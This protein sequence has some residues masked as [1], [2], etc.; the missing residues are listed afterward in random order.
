M[1][2]MIQKSC[3]MLTG[4]LLALTLSP[5][6]FPTADAAE[7]FPSTATIAE[8]MQRAND[9]W[10][11]NNGLGNAGWARGAYYTGNQRAV[12]VLGNRNY[13]R[14]ALAW[15]NANQWRVGPEIN[16]PNV[17]DAFCCG[18]TYIDLYRMD[19]KPL[20]LADIQAKID[21]QVASSAIDGWSWVD[22]FYMQAPT[23]A[24]LGSL[25]GDTN[26]FHKLR[27]MYDDM[28]IRRTLFDPEESLWYRDGDWV[29]PAKVTPSGKKVFWS[30]GDGWVF[31]GLARVIEEMPVGS[32]DR[33]EYVEM[34][35]RMAAAL[36]AV[37]SPDGMWRSSLLD[38]NEYP[39][40]ETSGTAFF[41]FGMAWGIRNGLLPAADYAD[42][43]IKGWN[44]MV[45][46]ALTPDGFLGY[47]QEVGFAPGP[48]DASMTKD[49][50]VGAFLLAGSELYLL[51]PDA[52][53]IRPWAGMDQTNSVKAGEKFSLPLNA[54]LTE[55]YKGSAVSFTWWNGDTQI[56]SGTNTFALL[57]PGQHEITLKVVGSDGNTY[58]DSI[59]VLITET[60]PPPAPEMKM[61]FGFEDSGTVTTDS[62]SGVTLEL[63]D[64]AGLP[65]DLHGAEGSGVFGRGRALDLRNGSYGSGGLARVINS[66][67]IN[68]GT[69]TNFAVSLWFKPLQNMW[70]TDKGTFF[71]LGAN[72]ITGY[73]QNQSVSL[74]CN[75]DSG[76]RNHNFKTAV[77][78]R[79]HTKGSSTSDPWFCEMPT[80]QW[81]FM[82]MSY[83]G[84]NLNFYRGT[85]TT[86]V[87]KMGTTNGS[88]MLNLSV[89]VGNS[90]S[91][92]IGNN[93]ARNATALGQFDDVRFYTGMV[94]E[95]FLEHTR[96]DDIAPML[97]CSVVDGGDISLRGQTVAG[98]TYILESSST[99][100]ANSWTPVLTNFGNGELVTNILPSYSADSNRFFR[101]VLQ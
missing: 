89:E 9:H 20:Y 15:G 5:G 10:I 78:A 62:I 75:G 19:P 82:A 74:R 43:V 37:Q 76:W 29:Y 45:N 36:K 95:A 86:P 31:A 52:P 7:S 30:R 85:E 46:I 24:R 27:L 28:K 41:T 53:A 42:T 4:G 2:Q 77:T 12:R 57:G 33:E 64:G 44:G 17:A 66:G 16:R 63:T 72:G 92:F 58:T 38:P 69:I 84:T 35:T 67:A 96:L 99:L 87:V 8:A 100:V 98:V 56:A 25:T 60:T 65:V 1:K 81:I 26:Y 34:F 14:R 21:A 47:V 3:V 73:G 22:A 51:A 55:I 88:E 13:L 71:A 61:K 11:A 39:N 80:N 94:D 101:W 93:A 68:F 48:A 59:S 40:P 18:Q 97:Q 90:F 6:L 79:I 32:P 54:G 50:G 83:D 23:M 91:L 70:S 49:Y